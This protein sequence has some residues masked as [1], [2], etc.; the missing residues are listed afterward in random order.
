[1]KLYIANPT[2][3]TQVV[4]YRLDYNKNGELQ[5]SDRTR[6]Q[7]ARQQDIA[8]GRQIQLGGDMHI[9]QIE[10]IVDQLKPYGIV[11]VV[12]IPQLGRKVVP[13]IFNIDRPVPAEAMRKV[14]NSNAAVLIE[15]GRDRRARAAV[16]S[17]E[18]VQN[19]VEHQ[20]L[21]NGIDQKPSDKIAVGFEQLDQSEAGEKTIAEGY[22]VSPHANNPKPPKGRRKGK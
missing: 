7:P 19:T 21:E 1:M 13:Y 11:G 8:P 16:A 2:R 6:F 5:E 9:T 10:D 18:I 3:Q 12:D 17:N 20:F 22:R 14:Q 4:C 15:D